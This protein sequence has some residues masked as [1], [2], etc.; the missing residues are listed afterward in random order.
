M[1]GVRLTDTPQAGADRLERLLE[2]HLHSR[3]GLELLRQGTPT[4]DTEQKDSGYTWRDDPDASFGPFFKQEPGYVRETDPTRAPRRAAARRRAVG[5]GDALATRIPGAGGSD[6]IE[7][8]AMQIALWPATIGYLMDTLLEP[9]FSD[10]AVAATREF[11][12]RQVS[13]RGPLPALRIAD[14]P[15]GIQP[16]VAFSRLSWFGERVP[17]A[18]RLPATVATAG[19]PGG[20]R[21]GRLCSPRVSRIGGGRRGPAPGAARRHRAASHVG[22]VLPAHRR[23]PASTRP[24][25]CRSSAP[26]WSQELIAQFPAQEPI[27]LLRKL[28][29]QGEEV[30]DILTKIYH[31]RQRPLDGPLVDDVPLSET[32]PDPRLRRRAQLRPVAG[33]RRGRQPHRGPGRAGAS[34]AGSRRRRCSTC[35]CAT[36]SSS[37]SGRP[38]SACS[39]RPG[40]LENAAVLRREPAFVHVD[41]DQAAHTESRYAELFTADE[42]VTGEVGLTVGDYISRHVRQ[43]EGSV[44]PEHLEALDLLATLPTARLERL[45]A[46]HVDTA[47]HRLD[48]WRTGLLGWALDQVRSQ[49]A[50]GTMVATTT[51]AG[52]V[53]GAP[54]RRGPARHRRSPPRRLRLGRGA[55]SRR[56]RR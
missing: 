53:G 20:G 23:Q 29:Y 41:A 45:L 40:A 19:A 47:S 12:T 30:P 3:S 14:Q 35:C 39:S 38:R 36:L 51:H 4:N 43:L 32:A 15:Y 22:G 9:V 11:F 48:A 16:A 37:A 28:G 50:K 10:A 18:A 7:A 2:H 33:R 1:L 52:A 6:R 5:L 34:T 42:R 46:E 49:P 17:D 13:G 8:R 31:A 21:T 54:V 55:A 27:D 44:L 26:S 24:T 25:S 56:A